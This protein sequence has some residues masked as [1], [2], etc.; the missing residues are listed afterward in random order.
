M[1]LDLFEFCTD[2][3]CAKLKGPRAAFKAIED[4]QRGPKTGAA[5]AD[6]SKAG[7]SKK[8]VEQAGASKDTG[9][10]A[11]GDSQMAVV[12][13][14]TDYTGYATGRY[15]LLAVLTH[16]GRTADSGHYVGWVKQAPDMWMQFDDETLV[17]R[18]DEDILPLCG[19]GDWHTAYLM[20]FKE[21][22]VPAKST[23]EATSKPA[24]A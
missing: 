18:K 11:D 4:A 23:T 17:P 6:S 19:G 3:L 5:A 2:E 9:K 24:A 7:N 10:D 15:E 8:A 22:T 14:E 1:M 20:L 13:D 12:E 21:Q 16:K